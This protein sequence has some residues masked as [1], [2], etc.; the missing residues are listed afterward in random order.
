VLAADAA[1]AALAAVSGAVVE[2]GTGTENGAPVWEVLVRTDDGSG[3][4]VYVDQASGAIVKQEPEELPDEARTAAPAVTAADA[5][6]TALAAVPG[7]VRD[8]DLG[9]E[10]GTVV[11]EVEVAHGGGATEV[12][13]DAT[14]G[15]IVKQEPAA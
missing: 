4:E 10:S 11:W 1:A 13:V 3:V 6:A 9:T 7:D 5:I 12:Y 2:I 15:E 8:V 14:T